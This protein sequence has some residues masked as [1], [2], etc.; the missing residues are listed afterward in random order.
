MV[1]MMK[2]PAEAFAQLY[3]SDV[4]PGCL[5]LFRGSWAFRVAH[6][7]EFQ[8]FLMLEGERAGQVFAIDRGMARSVAI[9]GEFRWIPM[10]SIHAKPIWGIQ[11][12]PVLALT[13]GRPV[14][15]GLD[16][17]KGWGENYLAYRVGDGQV[18]P[19]PQLNGT[20][21]FDQWSVELGHKDQ[22]FLSFGTLLEIDRREEARLSSS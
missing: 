11:N 2:L 1:D 4:P 18:A 19:L 21:H 7:T 6:E 10:V 15:V 12:V 13:P 17:D 20:A 16:S 3:P 14:L 22:P 5:F 8:G 9:V